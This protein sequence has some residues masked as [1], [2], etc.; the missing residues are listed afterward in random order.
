VK[1]AI[2]FTNLSPGNALGHD[3]LP[4]EFF[5]EILKGNIWGVSNNELKDHF[6]GCYKTRAFLSKI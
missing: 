2:C 3:G 6:D 4:I 1:L 5:Q